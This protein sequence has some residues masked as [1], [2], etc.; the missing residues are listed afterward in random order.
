M[1]TE[2][3]AEWDSANPDTDG[4]SMS[5]AQRLRL[6]EELRLESLADDAECKRNSRRVRAQNEER[7][8]KAL[9]F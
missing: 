4:R 6:I 3:K 7:T 5:E 8:R 2:R 1:L 9:R